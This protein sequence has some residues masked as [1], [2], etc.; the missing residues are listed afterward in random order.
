MSNF[1]FNGIEKDYCYYT[2]YTTSW[3]QDRE[4]NTTDVQGRSGTVLTSVRDKVRKIE[5]KL[6][7]G[8]RSRR[9]GRLVNN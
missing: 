8:T 3:G 5:V 6:L 7:V 2:D 1:S 9:Y 4:I